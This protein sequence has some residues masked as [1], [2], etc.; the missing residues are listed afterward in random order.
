MLE[1]VNN[2]KRE[3]KRIKWIRIS[4][5]SFLQKRVEITILTDNVEYPNA[6]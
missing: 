1:N 6:I 3:R 5:S 2:K 4:A